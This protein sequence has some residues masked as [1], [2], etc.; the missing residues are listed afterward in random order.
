MREKTNLF[1]YF[2]T[3]KQDYKINNS[4]SAKVKSYLADKNK[5]MLRYYFSV[6]KL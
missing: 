3:W 6:L 1:R 5:D 2:N 4:Y